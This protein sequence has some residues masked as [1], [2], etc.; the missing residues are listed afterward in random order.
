MK[1]FFLFLF[2][3]LAWL[4]AAGRECHTLL[5]FDAT[6]NFARLS[7]VD[8]IRYYLDKT[9]AAGFTDIVLDVKPISGEVL[10]SSTIA[11]EMKEWQGFRRADSFQFVPSMI[12]EA[13]RRGLRIHASLNIFAGGH[14]FFDRGIC[15]TQYPEWASTLYTDSGM[16][17]MMAVK[18][19]YST[20]LNPADPAIQHYELSILRELATRF[21]ELDGVILDR[22]RYDGIAADFSDVS[23]RLFEKYIGAVLQHFPQDVF[24]WTKNSDGSSR[25]A[26]GPYYN[27][28]LEW[29]AR[30]VHDFIA[31]ARQTIKA[32]APA[33]SFG[34][35]TGAW[36]PIYYEVGVNWASCTYDPANTHAWATLEYKN[37]GYAELLDLFTTGNYFFEVTKDEALAN[38]KAA[39]TETGRIGR[40]EYWYSVEGSCEIAAEVTRKVVPVYGGLYVEQYAGH[41]EQFSKAVTMCLTKSDGLM[42][43]DLIH[44]VN[45]NWWDLLGKVIRETH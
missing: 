31:A 2:A 39:H 27:K 21:P 9:K 12:K 6:A 14:N 18:S 23:R 20:M 17:G 43:F 13:H 45:Y 26:E 19:K 36:Y 7:C 44:I 4:P 32:V 42:V 8:S 37:T 29:R 11:P 30:I 33:M 16:V 5:W 28:W 35:Y 34:D 3:S 38:T 10:Y 15:Y 40:R 25:I 1:S 24:H 41:P 22:V